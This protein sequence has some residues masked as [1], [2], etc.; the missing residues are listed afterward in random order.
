MGAITMMGRVMHII[1][2]V[3]GEVAR[4]ICKVESATGSAELR[5]LSRYV[6]AFVAGDRLALKHAGLLLRK[7]KYL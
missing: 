2:S 1:I 7:D 3:G 4:C 5:P 6:T